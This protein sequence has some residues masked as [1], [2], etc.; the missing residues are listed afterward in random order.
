MVRELPRRESAA[1]DHPVLLL[2]VLCGAQFMLVLDTTIVTVALPLIEDDLGFSSAGSL[3]LVLSLYA[4]TFGGSL[5]VAG[6]AA[7]VWGP[8]PVFLLGL[9]AFTRASVGCGISPEPPILLAARAVQGTGAALASAAGLAA[10]TKSFPAGAPRNR[11]LS[12]WGAVGGAAGA[13][14]LVVGGLLTQTLG[15]RSIFLINLPVGAA[16]FVGAVA[17][18]AARGPALRTERINPAGAAALMVT[19]G[20]LIFGLTAVSDHGVSPWSVPALLAVALAA[21]GVFM[22]LERRT[23]SPVLPTGLFAIPST[24]P[25]LLVAFALNAVIASSLFFT[26]L[27]MQQTL[28]QGP[29]ATGLGFL[30]NS[31][32]VVVGAYLAGRLAAPLGAWRALTIGCSCITTGVVLLAMVKATTGYI[33]PVLPGFALIGLGLGFAFT[34]FTIM[35]TQ[36][37]MPSEQGSVSGVLNTAQQLGFAIGIATIVAVA[38]TADDP[39]TG[40]AIGYLIDAAVVALALAAAVLVARRTQPRTPAAATRTDRRRNNRADHSR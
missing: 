16:I 35:A 15:W 33:F 25:A 40:Y 36:H 18:L 22:L 27:F 8:K 19:L 23:P 30:P 26:T 11:A 17:V 2:W 34:A 39:L 5:I 32:L 24:T 21:G 10:L 37:A 4:L 20:S 13:A 1:P 38:Q 14:G 29:L 6:R 12:A 3:Q 7:D 28:G 31:A 9:T